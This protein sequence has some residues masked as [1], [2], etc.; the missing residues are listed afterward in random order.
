MNASANCVEMIKRFEG[1]RSEA[2]QDVAGVWTIGYGFTQGVKQGDT[3][4]EDEAT[5]RLEDE[6]SRFAFLLESCLTHLTNQNQFD[7]MLSLS[8]N[9]GM[10]NFKA[11][12]VLSNHNRG[13]SVLAA[14]SFNLWNHAGGKV[15]PGLTARRA[16]EA[17]LYQKGT[18]DADS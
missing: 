18:D 7:A 9:I 6:L 8:Y 16:A 12:S 10:G 4:T 3:I 2:Y 13:D 15:V 1:F 17:A 11:S 14:Q 5:L